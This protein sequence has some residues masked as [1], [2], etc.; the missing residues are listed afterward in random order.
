MG[1]YMKV[2]VCIHVCVYAC[3]HGRIGREPVRVFFCA[4]HVHAGKWK[5]GQKSEGAYSWPN[6]EM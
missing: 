6:G 1:T 4:S 3:A 2:C 5:E